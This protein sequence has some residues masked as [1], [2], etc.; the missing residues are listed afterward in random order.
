MSNVTPI[1]R[2]GSGGPPTAGAYIDSA[3]YALQVETLIGYME[4]RITYGDAGQPA[5]DLERLNNQLQALAQR[6]TPPKGAA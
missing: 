2:K 3:S 5:G 6:F 4:L 1:K